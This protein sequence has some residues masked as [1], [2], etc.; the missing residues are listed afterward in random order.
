MVKTK[1][2]KVGSGNNEAPTDE[3]EQENA[4][5]ENLS[6]GGTDTDQSEIDRGEGLNEAANE[7]V[8]G[9]DNSANEEETAI[10]AADPGDN[11]E[12][13]V[14]EDAV[15]EDEDVTSLVTD[16]VKEPDIGSQGGEH[17]GEFYPANAKGHRIAMANDHGHITI[18][19]DDT[20]L[21]LYENPNF[22]SELYDSERKTHIPT[23]M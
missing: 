13:E 11:V 1:T 20:A 10:D 8:E 19:D 12:D 21:I 5:N 15:V 2:I 6:G 14:A 9:D 23:N 3:V 4:T 16:E 17:E 18:I 22:Y 7:P